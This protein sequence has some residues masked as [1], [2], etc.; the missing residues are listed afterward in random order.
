MPKQIVEIDDLRH[1]CLFG[2]A[3]R[4]GAIPG[5][6]GQ[7]A[8]SD[9]QCAL[10]PA[11]PDTC[12]CVFGKTTALIQCR[13]HL[14]E[15]GVDTAWLT[16]DD[17]DND[18]SR[19][20]ACLIQAVAKIT[21]DAAMPA[22]TASAN[23]LSAADAA[24]D[25]IQHL[26]A[27]TAPFALILDDFECVRQPAVLGLVREIIDHL[28][29]RG[30]LFIGSRNHRHLPR[31]AASAKLERVR[32]LLFQGYKE[33]SK[34]ELQRVN[35]PQIWE[36]ALRLGLPAHDLEYFEL[37]RL[38]WELRVL[39]S[40]AFKNSGD[41]KAALATLD[42]VLKFTCKEGFQRLII[43][44]GN[45]IGN[46]GHS[47]TDSTREGGSKHRDP[48]YDEYLQRLLSGFG[49]GAVEDVEEEADVS[50]QQGLI[51]PLTSKEIRILLLLAEGYSNT[52]L[53]K[54][55]FISDSTV[56]THRRNITTAS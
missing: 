2:N 13:A 24:L 21:G 37:G 15:S 47:L 42:D 28:P 9:P 44:E 10:G 25:V 30:Q 8:R 43:D 29:R 23:G 49:P 33:A 14:E 35:E 50:G 51:E 40:L 36:R 12:A 27:Y 45:G 52:A 4:R 5:H 1:A 41:R 38:R 55:L 3:C 54:K 31:V 22:E 32:I 11:R 56:R 46:L 6:H 48:I 53:T 7:R 20:V 19:F 34:E 16:L 18:I 39:K 17:S 26:S